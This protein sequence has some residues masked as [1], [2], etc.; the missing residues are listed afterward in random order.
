MAFLEIVFPSRFPFWTLFGLKREFYTLCLHKKSIR[1]HTFSEKITKKTL[2]KTACTRGYN[3]VR[4]I[5]F[6]VWKLPYKTTFELFNILLDSWRAKIVILNF[7]EGLLYTV[8]TFQPR[9]F[10]CHGFRG[11]EAKLKFFV[12]SLIYNICICICV[13]AH[14]Q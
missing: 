6:L 13:I 12:D 9:V 5:D 14:L 11:K 8:V 3:S 10:R 1:V 7:S 2:L 4:R